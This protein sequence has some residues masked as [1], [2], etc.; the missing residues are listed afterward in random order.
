M[1]IL[2]EEATQLANRKKVDVRRHPGEVASHLEFVDCQ[3]FVIEPS[4][5]Q[6]SKTCDKLLVTKGEE[7]VLAK[8]L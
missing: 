3:S 1:R 8:F 2:F 5:D 4:S 7:E 6:Y